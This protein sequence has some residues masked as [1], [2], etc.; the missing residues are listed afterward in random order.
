MLLIGSYGG[1]L[2]AWMRAKYP[3]IVAGGIAGSAPIWQFDTL[4][5]EFDSGSYNRICSND[6]KAVSQNCFD[7]IAA[8]WDV[9]VKV[10]NVSEGGSLKQLSEAL[11]LCPGQ[12]KHIEN[13]T[14]V[15]WPWVQNVYSTLPMV[16]QRERER[17]RE[18][19]S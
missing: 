10:A 11:G 7:Q 12:L 14:N 16:R 19:E 6:F 17:E 3:N 13:V 1:M 5:K 2:T 15:I 9:M 4:T 8:S 18:R